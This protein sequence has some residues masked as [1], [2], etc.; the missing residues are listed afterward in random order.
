MLDFTLRPWRAEDAKDVAAAADNPRIA[1]NLRN[2]FPSPYTLADAEWFIGDCIAQG[3][4]RRLT[5]AIS[6]GGKAVGSIGVFVQSDVYE[7]S[8]EL[9]YWLAEACWGRGI[10]TEAVRRICREAFDRFDILRIYAEPF[11]DNLGSRRVLEKAGFTCEGTMRSGVYKNGRV[12]SY[13]IYSIL[14]EELERP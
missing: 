1:A 10:M 11:A 3:E 4:E 12:H 9:G 7:K 5:R 14:K 6:V 13:C 2:V 8:A